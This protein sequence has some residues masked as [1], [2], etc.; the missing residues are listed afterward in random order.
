MKISIDHV[1]NSSSESFATV[2]G[3]TLLVILFGIPFIA[4]TLGSTGESSDQESGDENTDGGGS[5]GE[6]DPYPSND[7]D[8][9][10]G[11]MIQKNPDGTVTKTLPDGTVGTRMPD[12]TVY[13]KAAD[14]T[15]G[16]ITPDGHETYTSPDGT[17]TEVYSD[18]TTYQQNPDGSTRT[19]YPDGTIRVH[20]ADGS[21]AAQNPDGT[22]EV[23]GPDEK[24]IQVLDKEGKVIG[25]KDD[26]GT[27][28]KK[29]EQGNISGV[30]VNEDGH[31]MTVTGNINDKITFSDDKGSKVV[32]NK[33]G[34]LESG[35]IVSEDGYVEIDENGNLKS[36]H[37]DKETGV[38]TEIYGNPEQGTIV[39][40]D[41]NGSDMTVTGDKFV[42]TMISD[43]GKITIDE[44]GNIDATHADGSTDTVRNNPDGS[45]SMVSKDANGVE[46]NINVKANGDYEAK[47]S[48][49]ESMTIIGN[50]DGTSTMTAVD[51]KGQV[52]TVHGSSTSDVTV[53]TPD[54][55]KI[56]ISQDG[57][58]KMTDKDGNAKSFT[59]EEVKNASPEM[60][61]GLKK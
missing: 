25:L 41:S 58:M 7:P 31:E 29:D 43:K 10:P 19:E 28:L 3:D 34:E 38:R 6:F 44:N 14:G 20:G 57:G 54:G 21:Y 46:T 52:T 40:K 4:A 12:G 48:L 18:G 27:N 15:T 32:I 42:G 53:N 39:I 8:D 16:V 36:D 5:S 9:E 22:L 17:K 45:S 50:S 13:V 37:T 23:R 49:G 60:F 35:K 47:N 2:I 1:T 11:T 55:G 51:A 61:G 56:I 24:N 59:P 33:D 30:A 26:N